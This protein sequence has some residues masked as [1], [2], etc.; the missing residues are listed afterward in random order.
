MYWGTIYPKAQEF[1][2]EDVF[3][4]GWRSDILIYAVILI[5]RLKCIPALTS[6]KAWIS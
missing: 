6:T 1:M 4:A 5:F 2:N 3:L